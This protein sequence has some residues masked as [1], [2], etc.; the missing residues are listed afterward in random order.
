MDYTLQN[1]SA[2]LSDIDKD[3]DKDNEKSKFLKVQCIITLAMKVTG[4][5]HL[6]TKH[7][8]FFQHLYHSNTS[9]SGKM[10]FIN[11]N[12]AKIYKPHIFSF[13]V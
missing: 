10:L 2:L 7:K 13:S 6:P 1:R 4:H 3:N 12:R 11:K 8:Y 5:Y 9:V